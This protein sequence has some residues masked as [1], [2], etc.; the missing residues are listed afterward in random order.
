MLFIDDAAVGSL[1]HVASL[2]LLAVLGVMVTVLVFIIGSG[3]IYEAVLGTFSFA[4]GVVVVS[5]LGN[6]V[7]DVAIVAV[8][9]DMLGTVITSFTAAMFTFKLNALSC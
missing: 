5:S 9:A 3:S 1:M 6:G 4:S 7:V 2:V 8:G